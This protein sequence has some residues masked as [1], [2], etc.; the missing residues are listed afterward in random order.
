MVKK[1]RAENAA[2]AFRLPFW[3]WLLIPAAIWLAQI[4]ADASRTNLLAYSEFKQLL[5]AGRITD[6]RLAPDTIRGMLKR[7]RL[8]PCLAEKR[9]NA[10]N[11]RRRGSAT[12]R[13]SGSPIGRWYR[14]LRPPT[15][16]SSG[17]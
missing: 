6:A 1:K 14:N 10:S 13:P 9:R 3:Y 16:I 17:N 8:R 15:C 2:S 5:H 12:F 7:T 11:V 4:A